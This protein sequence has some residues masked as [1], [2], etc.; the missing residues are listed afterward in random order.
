MLRFEPV[1][2]A[3]QP[4]CPTHCAMGTIEIADH[5]Q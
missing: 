1:S 2:R 3:S 4:C 5:C